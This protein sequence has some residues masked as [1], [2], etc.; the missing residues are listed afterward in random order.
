MLSGLLAG[1]LASRPKSGTAASGVTWANALVRVPCGQNKDGEAET[2]FVSLACFGS[3]A[4]AL[5][6]LDK[7]DTITAQGQLKPNEY[8]GKDGTQRH[9][10]SMT[11]AHLLTA[12]AVRRKRGDSEG[13]ANTAHA[14][15]IDREQHHAYDRFAR[16]VKQGS[17]KALDDWADT[18]IPF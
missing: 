15:H 6:R 17:T 16:G 9:G 12:Y 3:D 1:T 7:G 4:E 10:L 8:V 5:G 11:A 13:K 2:A 18:E 14:R